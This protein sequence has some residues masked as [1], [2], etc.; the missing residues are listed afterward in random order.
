MAAT[1]KLQKV[2]HSALKANQISIILL[3]ILAFVL[4][5]PWL[6]AFVSLVLGIGV[7]LKRP[8]FLPVYQYAFKPSGIL[9]PDVLDDNPEPHLF[10]QGIGFA[11]VGAGAIALLTGAT[12]L[13]WGLVWL[14]V[15]LAALNAFGGFC[16]GCA[17]YY[18]LGRLNVPGFTKAAPAGIIPG[19][20]PK[21]KSKTKTN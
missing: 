18:W 10:S 4:N 9:K 16:V 17:L 19:M 15:A 20:K 2:D 14:V 6:A 8:G 12:G 7:L 3:S 5:L 1:I 21:S 13:G 11:V